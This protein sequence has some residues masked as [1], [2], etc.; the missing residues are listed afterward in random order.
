MTLL[1]TSPSLCYIPAVVY[2]SVDFYCII[3]GISVLLAMS[4]GNTA[5][6]ATIK[7]V[8]CVNPPLLMY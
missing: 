3:S 6:L 2:F 8:T 7:L 5:G 1:R 4:G